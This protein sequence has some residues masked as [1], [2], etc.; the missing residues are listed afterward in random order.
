[1]LEQLTCP[2]CSAPLPHD[3]LKSGEHIIG[4][5][6][7]GGSIELP[8]DFK[9]KLKD[10]LGALAESD[11]LKDKN[12]KKSFHTNVK[13]SFKVVTLSDEA[14]TEFKG[15]IDRALK[16]LHTPDGTTAVTFTTEGGEIPESMKEMLA[17]M[18]VTLPN[19][20]TADAGVADEPD[21]NASSERPAKKSFWKRLRGK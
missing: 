5:P 6:Y 11:F 2:S 7:C 12:V 20:A 13:T 21:K 9:D 15:Q 3:L 19:N 8:E 14:K 17:K 4:C 10:M 1:M 16:D 18:G